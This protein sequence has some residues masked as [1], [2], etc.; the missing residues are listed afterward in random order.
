MLHIN[1]NKLAVIMRYEGPK[2]LADFQRNIIY[3]W[4]SDSNNDDFDSNWIVFNLSHNPEIFTAFF[5]CSASLENMSNVANINYAHLNADRTI[6]IIDS[7]Y[8]FLWESPS[9]YDGIFPSIRKYF[10]P[11]L[12]Q[13]GSRLQFEYLCYGTVWDAYN[14]KLDGKVSPN[15][16]L[17]ISQWSN[18]IENIND[19]WNKIFYSQIGYV[20]LDESNL[21]SL[22]CFTCKKENISNI[23][24]SFQ[25]STYI[26]FS[27]E[28]ETIRIQHC[29]KILWIPRKIFREL[30]INIINNFFEYIPYSKLTNIIHGNLIDPAR[31]PDKKMQIQEDTG[32]F[33]HLAP[34]SYNLLENVENQ[35]QYN[36]LSAVARMGSG[37]LNDEEL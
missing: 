4:V 25:P 17:E 8:K 36:T 34:K 35:K 11:T 15:K 3:L 16:N 27:R 2:M 37:T 14:L 9:G 31:V 20:I 6:L 33:I 5:D 12:Y 13:I 22:D 29:N 28:G 19:V 7:A 32:L 26:Y 21:F 18:F 1:I 24:K 30:F 23:D 10:K